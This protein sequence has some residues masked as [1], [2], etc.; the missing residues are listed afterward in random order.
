MPTRDRIATPFHWPEPWWTESY[1]KAANA[2]CGKAAS[3]SF[4]S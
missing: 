3:A 4:V 2:I 1:P